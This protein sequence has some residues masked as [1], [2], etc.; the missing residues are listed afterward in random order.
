MATTTEDAPVDYSLANPDTLTKY[1]TAAQISH[2]VLDE[3][4]A[5]CTEGAKIVD[6]CQK[7]DK[8]LEAEIAKV[9][10]GKKI[11][12]GI[13][14]PT[15][16]S[17]SAYVT[18]Y[19]PLVSDAEEAETTLSSGEAV[20]IQLGAQIDGFGTIV[21]DTIVVRPK[22]SEGVLSGRP[23]DL[24]LATH[25][26]NELLLRLM[27]PPGLVNAGTEEEQKKAA[28]QKPYSQSKMTQLLEKVVKSYNCSLVENTTCWVFE[29]NEIEGKKKIILAPGEGV[30]GEGLPEVGEVWGVEV[31]VSIGS[32]KVKTLSNRATLH[33]RTTTTYGLKRPSSRATL[34]E[35]K[36]KFGTFPFSLRQL[37][38]ERAGKV[39]IVECVRGGVVRQYEVIGSTDGEPVSRLF[40]TVAI[41]KN[42][43]QRLAAPPALNLDLYKSEHKITDE[44]VLKILEQPLANP[45]KPKA[46]K[47]K[48][49]KKPA[50]KAAAK[51]EEEDEESDE[52]DSDDE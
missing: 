18:P 11:V 39:G 41:T 15:T 12:K 51:P 43:L 3:V 45:T 36:Q 34:S 40:T 46:K 38:D 10:K 23:A 32:G 4:I 14:H 13:S 37:E 42:G 24:V 48:K 9:Y 28:A 44:E 20:K 26:A 47:N 35:I 30:K 52:E 33:R 7:G 1:K 21:C 2:K 29:R 22:G 5:L 31:G 19:T 17:P 27:V 50:K 8:I 49:K 25:Y 16:V 6:I